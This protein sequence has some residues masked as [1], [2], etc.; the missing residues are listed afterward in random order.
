MSD[1]L[2][3]TLSSNSRTSDIISLSSPYSSRN[4]RACSI[5]CSSDSWT[6]PFSVASWVRLGDNSK[7]TDENSI[8][9]TVTVHLNLRMYFILIASRYVFQ[10][11]QC[12]GIQSVRLVFS[13]TAEI[14]PDSHQNVV[15]KFFEKCFCI[16]RHEHELRTFV[17]DERILFDGDKFFILQFFDSVGDCT[18]LYVQRFC[19]FRRR[20]RAVQIDV[21]D[22]IHLGS[23]NVAGGD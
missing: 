18:F 10:D 7:M 15:Q 9:S 13:Q 21:L 6:S 12:C 23:G 16:L 22:D 1:S 3:L 20:R 19:Q 4:T 5:G 17:I 8:I 14:R 2:S 11:C